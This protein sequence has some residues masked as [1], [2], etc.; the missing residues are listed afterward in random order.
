VARRTAEDQF[1]GI[2]AGRSSHRGIEFTVNYA[3]L[4]RPASEI[5]TYFA[6]SLNDF[7]FKDFVDDG[8]DYSRNQLTGVPNQQWNT[9]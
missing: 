1:V 2:N 3:L 6:A 8:I 5:D 9:D 7:R 4:K